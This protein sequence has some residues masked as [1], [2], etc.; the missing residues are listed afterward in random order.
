M[1][2]VP[3][4]IFFHMLYLLDIDAED[5]ECLCLV[6][7]KWRDLTIE[8]G[9]KLHSNLFSIFGLDAK[10]ATLSQLRDLIIN[11]EI[12]LLLENA[13]NIDIS[14]KIDSEIYAIGQ[15]GFNPIVWWTFLR[16]YDNEDHM[17]KLRSNRDL[18]DMLF[19]EKQLLPGTKRIT[20]RLLKFM[21]NTPYVNNIM[22]VYY[23]KNTSKEVK[24]KVLEHLDHF[25][26]LC[27]FFDEKS[28]HC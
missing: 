21:K 14:L 20:E 26:W 11:Q 17:V 27:L 9:G 12:A 18:F 8:Y 22:F 4:E 10:N 6:S 3:K 16:E 23:T 1:N 2:T 7:K 28:R 5:F 24:K 25:Y 19:D 13:N 15:I